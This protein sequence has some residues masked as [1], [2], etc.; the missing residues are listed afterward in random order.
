MTNFAPGHKQESKAR[1]APFPELSPHPKLFS[2]PACPTHG[3][4]VHPGCCPGRVRPAVCE[5]GEF[6][7]GGERE[8]EL[9][10]G[11]F[12]FFFPCAL[13]GQSRS[14]VR[15]LSKPRSRRGTCLLYLGGLGGRLRCVPPPQTTPF[16]TR[17]LLHFFFF[18]SLHRSASCPPSTSPGSTWPGARRARWA[19]TPWLPGRTR[20][21]QRWRSTLSNGGRQGGGRE[22]LEAPPASALSS[23]LPCALSL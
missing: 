20:R 11:A 1:H 13:A 5:R 22:Q 19:P 15:V 3:R 23:I 17:L 6:K 2:P 7:R 9:S 8:S 10:G 18:V 14:Q 12:F 21:G 4:R 16:F